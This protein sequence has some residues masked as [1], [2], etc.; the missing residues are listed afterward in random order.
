MNVRMLEAH[1]HRDNRN[2]PR[3]SRNRADGI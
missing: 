1:G 3:K 2:P